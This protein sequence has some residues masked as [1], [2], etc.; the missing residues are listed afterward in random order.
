[1]G[2]SQ[3]QLAALLSH[4]WPAIEAHVREQVACEIDAA[5]DHTLA[6]YPDVPAMKVRV[7]GQRAAA[8]IARSTTTQ[9]R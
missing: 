3:N 9:E 5:A 6:E 7:I 1:M 8:R 4:Y 2:L